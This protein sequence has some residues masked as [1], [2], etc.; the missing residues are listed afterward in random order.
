M[1]RLALTVAVL[2]VFAAGAPAQAASAAYK[3][4]DGVSLTAVFEGGLSSPGSAT[5]TFADGGVMKLPQAMSAD[6]GRYVGGGT[7]FW[8]KGRGA[9]LTQGGRATTCTTH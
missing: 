5:L 8:I 3:C 7:E 4:E 2:A 9:T 6:G 1:E